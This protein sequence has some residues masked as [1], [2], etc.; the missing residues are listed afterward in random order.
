VTNPAPAKRP[1]AWKAHPWRQVLLLL[2]ALAATFG[3]LTVIA[4]D[5]GYEPGLLLNIGCGVFLVQLWWMALR[6]PWKSV[7]AAS[8]V[9]LAAFGLIIGGHFNMQHAENDLRAEFHRLQYERLA[10][11]EGE[12]YSEDRGFGLEVAK[13]FGVY[14][15]LVQIPPNPAGQPAMAK[16]IEDRGPGW[17]V[18]LQGFC[19]QGI[20]ER[21]PRENDAYAR[22]RYYERFQVG[23]GHYFSSIG[24]L[25]SYHRYS[26]YVQAEKRVLPVAE[27][28]R[29]IFLKAWKNRPPEPAGP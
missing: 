3:Y 29:E 23:C 7:K 1:S 17:P 8:A 15:N 16:L 2:A 11:K 22:E 5:Y 24:N 27:A 18:A 4:P 21:P 10:V 28:D 6:G 20:F 25:T 14:N 9:A 19:R 12:F 13:V 26:A